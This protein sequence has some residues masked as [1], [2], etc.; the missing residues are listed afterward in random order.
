MFP[1][2]A[3]P[4][5]LLVAEEFSRATSSESSRSTLPKGMPS[6][7]TSSVRLPAGVRHRQA[8]FWARKLLGAVLAAG[9][10]AC[11]GDAQVAQLRP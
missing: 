8:I 2:A 7:R 6:L 5:K 1:E 9:D 11:D 3:M 4:D 10:R